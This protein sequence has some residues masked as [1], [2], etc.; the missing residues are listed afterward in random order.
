MERLVKRSI[1]ILFSVFLSISAVCGKLYVE[2]PISI[3]WDP[4]DTAYVQEL[5][6]CT[7]LQEGVWYSLGYID[8]ALTNW[9]HN[10]KLDTAFFRI[11]KVPCF[12]AQGCQYRVVDGQ[13]TYTGDPYEF[14]ATSDTPSGVTNIVFGF[15][16]M[17]EVLPVSTYKPPQPAGSSGTVGLPLHRI[18]L[19]GFYGVIE[20]RVLDCKTGEWVIQEPYDHSGFYEFQIPAWN[21]YWWLG[22]WSV[23]DQEYKFYK[24]MGHWILDG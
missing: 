19:P 17:D 3:S 8:P 9:T 23:Q 2:S 20:A 14:Y 13:V 21:Q 16:E 7:N 18:A 22:M 4:I 24:Y 5:Q 10:A 11:G 1:S 12:A 15:S 6:L